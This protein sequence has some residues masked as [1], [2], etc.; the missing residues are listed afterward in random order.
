M[1]SN[2]RYG[3]KINVPTRTMGN[4]QLPWS[5]NDPWYNLGG[6]LGL[7]WADNFNKRGISKGTDEMQNA[8]SAPAA[9]PAPNPQV[10]SQLYQQGVQAGAIG[11]GSTQMAADKQPALNIKSSGAGNI[12]A[13]QAEPSARDKIAIEQ[14]D[15]FKSKYGAG[16]DNPE[17]D[18]K[19]IAADVATA[20]DAL[21]KLDFTQLPVT[22]LE[23]MK[24][25]AFA[26]A[27]G[28]TD[29]QKQKAWEAI[30][31]QAKARVQ[32]NINQASNM[33]YDQY[34]NLVNAGRLDDS[35]VVM[36]KL[37]E[38]NP[39]MAKGLAPQYAR[40]QQDFKRQYDFDKKVQFYKN[41]DKT[42]T[43]HEANNY[44][45]YNNF[46]SPK[47]Q[48]Q[49]ALQHGLVLGTNG[50]YV[51]P[52]GTGSGKGGGDGRPKT[53]NSRSSSKP[54]YWQF[55]GDGYRLVY[56]EYNNLV[57]IPEEQRTPEEKAR[58]EQYGKYIESAR[59][60]V[61]NID[62]INKSEREN[63]VARL[64]S[65]ESPVNILAGYPA[66]P[67]RDL[68]HNMILS[69]T[70]PNAGDQ[71][72]IM[73]YSKGPYPTSILNYNGAYGGEDFELPPAVNEPPADYMETFS[74]PNYK[75]VSLDPYEVFGLK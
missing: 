31:P 39:A 46:R 42:L 44:A 19:V 6:L 66:G 37:A 8:I 64:Q 3:M 60:T 43:D 47:E 12:T 55:G 17:G 38:L 7:A 20:A 67:Q 33:L 9:S 54:G 40:N 10:P 15:N 4:Q 72:L 53:D 74:K 62:L 35:S 34:K 56:N 36:A 75:R 65:G 11:T 1:S 23:D 21:N 45:L 24:A 28:R 26:A 16:T 30:L 68:A 59:Q 63:I 41:N 2:N 32:A 51:R 49:W 25:M 22:S 50:K 27:K 71:D 29:Y 57:K 18:K 69:Y 61:P 70:G 14:W 52:T 73:P 58:I 48:E 5:Q 13:G